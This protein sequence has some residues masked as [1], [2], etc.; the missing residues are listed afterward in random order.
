MR[1]SQKINESFKLPPSQKTVLVRGNGPWWVCFFTKLWSHESTAYRRMSPECR[2]SL[3]IFELP[4][5][6]WHIMHTEMDHVVLFYLTSNHQCCFAEPWQTRVCADKSELHLK[7]NAYWPLG[8]SQ[9]TY[10]GCQLKLSARRGR[11]VFIRNAS[12]RITF[13]KPHPVLLTHSQISW[14]SHKMKSTRVCPDYWIK[15]PN[16]NT[17]NQYRTFAIQRTLRHKSEYD[18]KELTCWDR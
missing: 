18:T 11:A 13:S 1:T 6:M 3:I 9:N 12:L 14:N 5:S 7:W 17:K 16:W 10:G 15:A 4:A 8:E 2:R